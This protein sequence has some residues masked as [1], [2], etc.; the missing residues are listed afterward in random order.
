MNAWIVTWDVLSD[1]AAVADT[2]AAILPARWGRDRVMA[3]VEFLY[4]L[5]HSTAAEL[6]RYAR[7]PAA[8]P[9]RAESDECGWIT[10]GS[11][12]F[13]SAR[14]AFKVTVAVD[15]SSGLETIRWT[16]CARRRLVDDRVVEVVPPRDELAE[17]RIRGPLSSMPIWDRETAR[18]RPGWGP[19]ETP[20]SP[21]G[22]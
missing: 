3:H 21:A 11:H 8:N 14:P 15:E 9:Y 17:R 12:P 20:T 10:C 6:A 22:A 19:G 4:A 16:N 1:A 7:S 5:T 13:L 18:F 2:L